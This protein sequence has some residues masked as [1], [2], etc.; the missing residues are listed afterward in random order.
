MRRLGLMLLFAVVIRLTAAAQETTGTI[1]GVTTDSTGGV[2]PGVTVTLKSVN[3]GAVRSVVTNEAGIYIA[4]GLSVGTY[5]VTFE[6]QGFQSATQRNITLHVNDRLQIDSRMNVG[7][8]AE[9]V[10][11]SAAS[12]L[13]QPIAALQTTMGTQQVQELPLNNRNFVQLATLAPGVSSDLADEVGVGLASTVSMSINGARRNAVNWLVDGVSNVDV[14][15]NITLLSTP[16]LES[17]EEFKIITNGYQA[18]WP[19]SGGGIVNVVT[20]SGSARFSGSVYEFLRSDKLNANSFFRN[21]STDPNLNGGPSKL[22]YNNFGG[23]IG[24]PA[25]PGKMFFFFSEEL[26]RINRAP[27]SLTANVYDPSWLTDPANENYVAPALRDPNAVKLLAMWPAP[28]VPGRTQFVN[29]APNINNTRQ[30]VARVDYDFNP[31]WRLTGRYSHDN[32]FTRE[33]TGLFLQIQVP[34]VAT[35]DTNVPGQVAAAVLRGVLGPSKMNELQFQFSSNRISDTTPDGTLNRQ[36]D[37]GV[38]L[39]EVFPGNATG[40]VPF[41]TVTGMSQVGAN[42]L[43]N[44]EYNNYTVTDS[45]TWQRGTHSFK[46]GGLRQLRRQERERGQP[47]PGQLHL[48][49]RRRP[50]RVPELPDRQC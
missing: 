29:S 1:T 46:A 41:I 16:S 22:K 44:I 8:V 21:L 43:F 6:L 11:V 13:I 18:E 26:R 17:I 9:S 30:E 49:R 42:Q 36:S 28:N 5:E 24:G 40:V 4:S 19:R 12:P 14:G 39:G 50:H 23:T 15:S 48:R 10:I 33:P 25:I 37:Y 45:F 35:T 3:T 34:N 2:L 7:G 47:D 20:K 31:S 38:T 27:A 32:S